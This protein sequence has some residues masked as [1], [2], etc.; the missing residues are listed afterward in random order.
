[1]A[2]PANKLGGTAQRRSDSRTAAIALIV[3]AMSGSLPSQLT[4]N[5][6]KG[7]GMSVRANLAGGTLKPRGFALVLALPLSLVLFA[8]FSH[9]A[10]Q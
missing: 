3:I 10:S 1:M 4:K 9:S 7:I 2:K 8:A 5:A 6:V